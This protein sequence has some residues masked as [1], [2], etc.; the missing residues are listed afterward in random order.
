MLP[1]AP[2]ARPKMLRRSP[3]PLRRRRKGR[4]DTAVNVRA[5]LVVFLA[6]FAALAIFRSG[7]LVST[8]YDLPPGETSE[9]VVAAAETW[10]GWME[11]IGAA[12]LGEAVVETVGAFASGEI[13]IRDE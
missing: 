12:P 11:A 10:H 4:R 3:A 2:V 8:S 9:A 13:F 1:S 6:T 7:D 5:G